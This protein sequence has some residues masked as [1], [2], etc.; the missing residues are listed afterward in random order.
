MDGHLDLVTTTSTSSPYRF[1]LVFHMAQCFQGEILSY[2]PS[3]SGGSGWPPKPLGSSKFLRFTHTEIH[4]LLPTLEL[5]HT[6]VHNDVSL[7]SSHFQGAAYGC[8]VSLVSHP[9][10]VPTSHPQ[11]HL[12][13][14]QDE[15]LT[16]NNQR[17]KEDKTSPPS[18]LGPPTSR[19]IRWSVSQPQTP[20]KLIQLWDSSCSGTRSAQEQILS[21]VDF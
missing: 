19:S 20:Q 14:D 21:D 10:C 18:V 1:W 12:N 15:A 17:W 4:A 8:M 16:E 13:S 2:V 11:I 6:E 7:S 9:G 5:E 3:S